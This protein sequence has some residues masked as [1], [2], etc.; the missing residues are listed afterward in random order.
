M[1]DVPIR[2]VCVLDL[3]L[4]PYSPGELYNSPE[5][6]KELEKLVPLNQFTPYYIEGETTCGP[7]GQNREYKIVFLLD[8]VNSLQLTDDNID[9]LLAVNWIPNTPSREY[10][11]RLWMQE[12]N[13]S[14]PALT[15]DLKTEV[16]KIDK[17]TVSK[18]NITETSD[19]QLS[20]IEGKRALYAQV[21][22]GSYS[23]VPHQNFQ[24]TSAESIFAIGKEN[25]GQLSV[26]FLL[27][28]IRL[29]EMMP[30]ARSVDFTKVDTNV[31]C[32]TFKM[33]RDPL[34]ITV[35]F[36]NPT[37][38]SLPATLD[39]ETKNGLVRILSLDDAYKKK[40][41]ISSFA[42]ELNLTKESEVEL[43]TR[44]KEW[45]DY[46]TAFRIGNINTR[47]MT[48][49]TS[50]GTTRGLPTLDPETILNA[51]D[52]VFSV[53]AP[54]TGS[55][56]C[57]FKYNK[58]EIN[59]DIL[60]DIIMNDPVIAS[61]LFVQESTKTTHF[62]SASGTYL[63]C[64]IVQSFLDGQKV[65]ASVHQESGKISDRGQGYLVV[66]AKG[67]SVQD[68]KR[69]ADFFGL[70]IGVY[71]AR[72]RQMT[73][74]YWSILSTCSDNPEGTVSTIGR[75]QALQQSP[76]RKNEEQSRRLSIKLAHATGFEAT[77]QVEE[78][79][80][81]EKVCVMQKDTCTD[82][83]TG[84]GPC[85]P[86]P[87][88][89]GTNRCTAPLK[90]SVSWHV[91]GFSRRCN[92]VPSVVDPTHKDEMVRQGYQV[93]EF[94]IG[95]GSYLTC[96][97]GA[98]DKNSFLYLFE[99]PYDNA[100]QFP[101]LPCC[102][103]Q[104]PDPRVVPSSDY[105]KYYKNLDNLYL[106]KDR[107]VDYI[108]TTSEDE[109][110][111]K[112]AL[113]MFLSLVSSNTQNP[114]SVIGL[115]S[116]TGNNVKFLPFR[117]QKEKGT[118][119]LN[120]LGIK[121]TYTSDTIRDETFKEAIIS[122]PDNPQG[123][124]AF[125]YW[126]PPHLRKSMLTARIYL[127]RALLCSLPQ[128]ASEKQTSNK[129]GHVKV[130]PTL[131]SRAD[132]EH[133][134]LI[135]VNTHNKERKVDDDETFSRPGYSALNRYG[136][137]PSEMDQ[138]LSLLSIN[139]TGEKG[140]WLRFGVCRAA[141][142]YR[143]SVL[144][145]LET[146]LTSLV[147]K[148]GNFPCEGLYH[149]DQEIRKAFYKRIQDQR[150]G[151]SQEKTAQAVVGLCKQSM[152]DMNDN[153]I[154]AYL[155]PENS[156]W[157]A[158]NSYLDPR[159]FHALLQKVY[160]VNIVL[161]RKEPSTNAEL[162]L[163]RHELQYIP[164]AQWDKTV[165]IYE[166]YGRR[167][168]SSTAYPVCELVVHKSGETIHRLLAGADNLGGSLV[169]AWLATERSFVDGK[170]MTTSD[171]PSVFLQEA[172]Q[173]C[174]VIGPYGKCVGL[175]YTSDG[176]VLEIMNPSGKQQGFAPPLQMPVCTDTYD[177]SKLKSLKKLEEDCGTFGEG[178]T[179]ILLEKSIRVKQERDGNT[180]EIVLREVTES[181]N[182]DELVDFKKAQQM[183]RYLIGASMYVLS[184]FLEKNEVSLPI[185]LPGTS[186][187]KEAKDIEKEVR[188]TWIPQF[189]QKMVD[190][191]EFPGLGEKLGPGL[192]PP[193]DFFSKDGKMR[194]G[195]ADFLPTYS[196]GAAQ[197]LQKKLVSVLTTAARNDI[198]KIFRYKEFSSIPGGFRQVSDFSQQEGALIYS[199][200]VTR[201][202]PLVN[203]KIYPFPTTFRKSPY[204]WSNTEFSPNVYFSKTFTTQ[205][206]GE[207][208]IASTG[209]V[210]KVV[211]S[212]EVWE[213]D[214][215][216]LTNLGDAFVLAYSET[217][218]VSCVIKEGV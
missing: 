188:D 214:P 86:V 10:L 116:S 185:V 184:R 215:N 92:S 217:M 87:W 173:W 34:I 160:K 70:V 20:W 117:G 48:L 195:S 24:V 98:K 97:K 209:K 125:G 85:N 193:K 44:V 40:R 69:F 68:V 7:G 170:A 210:A 149:S 53:E 57:S 46:R 143:V 190:V 56:T 27:D 181:Q 157:D 83:K 137:L 147:E 41:Y 77:D 93:V 187:W 71:K 66:E 150:W 8:A 204:Y 133:L 128:K 104:D 6:M 113:Q 130:F 119:F 146:A 123:A 3:G 37:V 127:E 33:S 136:M 26:D 95:S 43:S 200:Q 15:E 106:S 67:E 25:E 4:N 144:Y 47:K 182:Q 30:M 45:G 212:S 171:V 13:G 167:T 162:V 168:V 129:E 186:T 205:K 151:I 101:Y 89:D 54:T 156:N 64:F 76:S 218:Y 55:T 90:A 122:P 138:Y 197:E 202:K 177:P 31:N 155:L 154:L 203:N 63:G 120:G 61:V 134:M 103:T 50:V 62:S 126:K 105:N 75:L 59:S 88:S 22:N 194:I 166:H 39:L 5:V 131:F 21:T 206:E 191:S 208:W 108:V 213:G 135:W 163:P 114:L 207:E 165:V 35:L 51:F 174:Q 60:C 23:I 196:D 145:C 153:Q 142:D 169:N 28:K 175:R 42:K 183:A 78:E 94:P 29:T 161:F 79:E 19:D 112:Q 132:P 107:Y 81:T 199:S 18:V 84:C 176:S 115:V 49:S 172:S 52:H 152:Y 158:I 82:K 121:T 148:K 32:P 17:D 164:N 102:R 100:K 198:G 36:K 58:C 72:E 12:G 99:N 111:L 179:C 124:V 73:Y 159:M 192:P 74:E 16:K 2:S 118:D 180:R 189:F 38:I 201:P 139:N 211:Q 1:N 216:T 11:L 140:Q 80:C 109:D 9:L 91:G 178:V 65:R 141:K 14:M 110:E 96:P